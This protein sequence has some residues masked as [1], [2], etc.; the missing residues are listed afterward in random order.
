VSI[1]GFGP[2]RYSLY[3]LPFLISGAVTLALTVYVVREARPRLSERTVTSLVAMLVGA[4]GWP[5]VAFL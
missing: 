5:F 3:L 2:L 4:A 1:P